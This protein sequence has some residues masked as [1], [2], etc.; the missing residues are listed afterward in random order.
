MLIQIPD[1]PR[2]VSGMS[3]PAKARAIKVKCQWIEA[4]AQA[5][6]THVKFFPADEKWVFEVL[7]DDVWF[8]LLAIWFPAVVVSPVRY[9]S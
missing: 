5:I 4:P 2:R 1:I 6:D 9:L 3:K 8:G 7:L